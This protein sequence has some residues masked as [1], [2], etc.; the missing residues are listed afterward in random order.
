MHKIDG[1]H[2]QCVNNHHHVK[3]EYK[4][5]NT[6]GVPEYTNKT[7][8]KEKMSMFNTPQKLEKKLLNVHKI[9]GE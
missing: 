1:A 5:M 6:L 8:R 7:F 2:L 9:K 3:F 4:G